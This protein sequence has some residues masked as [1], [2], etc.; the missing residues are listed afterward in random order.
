M[1]VKTKI[2]KKIMGENENYRLHAYIKGRVQGVG[3]RY[4]TLNS[5]REYQLRGWVRNLHDGRVEV[6][7]EGEHENLNRLLRDLRKGPISAEV[8]DVDYEFTDAKGEFD[9]FFVRQTV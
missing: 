6:V 2:G 4:H 8:A 9:R 3:F 1:H 5:A 7:A